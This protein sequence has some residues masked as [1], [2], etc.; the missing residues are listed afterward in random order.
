MGS[1]REDATGR[2]EIRLNARRT[3]PTEST[4]RPGGRAAGTTRGLREGKETKRATNEEGDDSRYGVLSETPPLGL[5]P[6]SSLRGLFLRDST[7]RFITGACGCGRNDRAAH[8][9]TVTPERLSTL[10]ER[11]CEESEAVDGGASE[12]SR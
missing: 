5:P 4:K 10:A 6:T 8:A 11:T 1:S 3:L 9:T 7:A 12:T 2:V